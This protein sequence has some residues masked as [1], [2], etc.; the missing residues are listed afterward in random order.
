MTTREVRRNMRKPAAPLN[1][2]DGN[3]TPAQRRAL[4]TKRDAWLQ[5]GWAL[6]NMGVKPKITGVATVR[7]IFGTNRPNQRRDPH[8]F[9]P[10]LKYVIDGL[11]RAGWWADDDAK[12]V[13]TVEPEFDGLLHP[14]L[15][16]VVVTWE[17]PDVDPLH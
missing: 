17:E 8:N 7:L 1:M 13:R 15:F 9:A 10:T 16:E 5:A 11:T 4:K 3:G 6:G 14:D 12:H 2:N